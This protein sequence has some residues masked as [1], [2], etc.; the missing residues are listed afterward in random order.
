[1]EPEAPLEAASPATAEQV[2][3]RILLRGLKLD[4]S[5]ERALC[6]EIRSAILQ[7]ISH[8]GHDGEIHVTSFG[9][10]PQARPLL[11]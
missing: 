3:F 1:M 9:A 6:Q 8:L 11:G 5:T 10:Q 7:E 4:P 2:E